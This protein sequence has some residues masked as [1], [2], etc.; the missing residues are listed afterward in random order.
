[1]ADIKIDFNLGV[2][3][4]NETLG[5]KYIKE[6]YSVSQCSTSASDI[7]YGTMENSGKI[8]IVDNDKYFLGLIESG[9]ID[10]SNFP[11]EIKINGN[12]MQEHITSNNSYN[13][14][15]S[16][17]FLSLSNKIK[18]LNFLIFEG[19]SLPEGKETSRT[20]YEILDYIFSSLGIITEET[21]MQQNV[22][23]G[24]ENNTIS[25]Y[26]YLNSIVIEYPY[27][28][29][30]ITYRDA[31]NKIC[32]TAQL[33]MFVNDKG[34]IKFVSARP[35]FDINKQKVIEIKDKNIFSFINEEI[36]PQNRYAFVEIPKTKVKDETI[37][38]SVVHTVEFDVSNIETPMISMENINEFRSKIKTKKGSPS[39]FDWDVGFAFSFCSESNY[40][41][42]GRSKVPFYSNQNLI[43]IKS[44][45]G[46]LFRGDGEYRAPTY[47]IKYT[48]EEY[49]LDATLQIKTSTLPSS[50]GYKGI[51][52]S[53]TTKLK[54]S[55][56]VTGNLS[57]SISITSEKY[58]DNISATVN[59]DV[60]EYSEIEQVLEDSVSKSFSIPFNV[61]VGQNIVTL[62][63][64]KTIS[65]SDD[66]YG[67]YSATGTYI[68]RIPISVEISFY[69]TK[70]EIS[71]DTIN[72]NSGKNTDGQVASLKGNELMQQTTTSK[73]LNLISEIKR[74]V[75]SDYKNGILELE[76]SVS[77]D[78]YY[79]AD[80]TLSKDWSAGQVLEVG[81]IVTI[82]N[83]KAFWK[84]IS[85]EFVYDAR[86]ILNLRLSEVFS[87]KEEGAVDSGLYDEDN[88]LIY[89]WDALLENG[90][91]NQEG[92]KIVSS[93]ITEISGS[94]VISKNVKEIGSMAFKDN[95]GLKGVYISKNVNKIGDNPFVGCSNLSS[96]VVSE[97]NPVYDSRNGCNA[98]IYEDNNSGY[99]TL[100]CGCKTTI[101]PDDVE[102]IGR[103]S[104]SGQTGFMQ[105][106]IP[107]SVVQIS[108]YAFQNTNLSSFEM[109]NS[110]DF[111]GN[112]VFAGCKNLEQVYFSEK[113]T[114]FSDFLFKGC[115]NLSGSFYIPESVNTIGSNCFEGCVSLD[116]V[117]FHEN[118]YN[119][120]SYLFFNCK[121]GLVVYTKILSPVN[122][123][124]GWSEN[125]HIISDENTVIILY[126]ELYLPDWIKKGYYKSQNSGEYPEQFVFG[127]D[128]LRESPYIGVT[129][130]HYPSNGYNYGYNAGGFV[131]VGYNLY[132]IFIY[133][134]NSQKIICYGEPDSGLSPI[135]L[136]DSGS[137]YFIRTDLEVQ[138]NFYYNQFADVGLEIN[139]IQ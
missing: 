123:P 61:A 118:I 25:L 57:S 71:F 46:T 36:I 115:S 2:Q 16:E 65:S 105:I 52:K 108:D 45:N 38:D 85:R 8:S 54:S 23:F 104:F 82:P 59:M 70:R 9:A 31:L 33:Q 106:E 63:G 80:G 73:Y 17:M 14:T 10:S 12:K 5:K 56:T 131:G 53:F 64:G 83:N 93:N 15:S 94:L 81:D 74:N 138:E 66:I 72:D 3:D 75:F 67:T 114:T 128:N 78:N 119:L 21:L 111:C 124:T 24:E 28:P 90:Y 32:E 77:C 136:V 18:N 127:Y 110:I 88:N 132:K 98:I 49:D 20:L 87:I 96:I 86:P 43:Q 1:M 39:L 133:E 68:R 69:G 41:F 95:T 116:N 120:G 44:I 117:I 19:Y 11:L 130:S 113:L 103:Y 109:P 92:F 51:I 84:I 26:D 37:L 101:I 139:S 134:V 102:I 107:N 91:I 34:V 42:S 22:V 126:S 97:E 100:I 55:K 121:E 13:K 129:M 62:S 79:F 29:S 30:G 60:L 122:T 125:W 40:N 47:T 137:G 6:L 112:G 99:T 27:I 50:G 7:F 135:T 58:K 76:V 4:G 35:V 48:E 89:T